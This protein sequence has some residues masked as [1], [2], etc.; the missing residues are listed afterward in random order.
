MVPDERRLGMIVNPCVMC[1]EETPEGRMV[2]GLCEN[3]EAGTTK[4]GITIIDF[5]G[6]KYLC[7]IDLARGGKSSDEQATEKEGV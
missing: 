6:K 2:C 7:G 1:G 4:N 5:R 3:L